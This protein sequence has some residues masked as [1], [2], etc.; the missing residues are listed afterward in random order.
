[1]TE[2]PPSDPAFQRTTVNLIHMAESKHLNDEQLQVQLSECGWGVSKR[3]PHIACH[4]FV[5]K[6][7]MVQDGGRRYR[8]R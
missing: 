4:E 1:M 5:T 3:K 6:R 7:K 2:I 8:I